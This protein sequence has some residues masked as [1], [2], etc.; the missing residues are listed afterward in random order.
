MDPYASSSNMYGAKTPGENRSAA[1]TVTTR[2]RLHMDSRDRDPTLYPNANDFRFHMATPIRGV[3]AITLTDLW[4]PLIMET[5][6]YEEIVSDA[7]AP[8]YAFTAT[9]PPNIIVTGTDTQLMTLP[10]QTALTPYGFTIRV[11]NQSADVCTVEDAASV[12]QVALSTGETGVFMSLGPTDIN[13]W[14]YTT[15]L[16]LNLMTTVPA[17]SYVVPVLAGLPENV[18]AQ[19]REGTGY[20]H[21]ALGFVP[22]VPV[23]AALRSTYYTGL[24]SDKGQGGSWRVEFPFAM[25]QLS[26][27]H[28]QMYAWGG[29]A[30]AT[31]WGRTGIPPIMYPFSDETTAHPPSQYDNYWA[32]VEI[33]H[34]MQ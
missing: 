11:H 19:Y 4:C 13:G 6:T 16:G 28:M 26:E 34:V 10:G 25:G 8:P 1:K 9:G 14:D 31:G 2:M 27:L 7:T 17:Y 15:S 5:L 24:G 30:T 22:L 32:V 3:T 20:P 29:G 12:P 21:G 33:E 18:V 23:D